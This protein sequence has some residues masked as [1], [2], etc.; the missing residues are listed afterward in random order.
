MNSA[1]TKYSR[2]RLY[3]R[4]PT[5]PSPSEVAT[6]K[7]MALKQPGATDFADVVDILYETGIRVGEL[8]R[9]SWNDVNFDRRRLSVGSIDR[10][11]PITANVSEI[12]RRRREHYPEC[13]YVLG[14][15]P[16]RVINCVRQQF[17]QLTRSALG[18]RLAL[19]SL[20]HAFALRWIKSGGDWLCLALILGHRSVETT[21]RVFG[22]PKQRLGSAAKAMAALKD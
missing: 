10:S 4:P 8:Q 11:V 21:V 19:H 6:L 14:S 5:P 3:R 20:R 22:S 18:R 15:C 17:C 13:P 7:R 12:L 16:R 2:P 1:N 9:L